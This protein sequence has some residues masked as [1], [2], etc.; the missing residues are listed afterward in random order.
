M[1]ALV[2]VL[3][4]PVFVG[5]L[6]DVRAGLMLVVVPVMAVG[7]CF[8]AMLVLMLVFVV[9]AHLEFTSFSLYFFK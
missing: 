4:V 5:V 2:F 7:K 9:A 8:V 6:V 3:M 1:A